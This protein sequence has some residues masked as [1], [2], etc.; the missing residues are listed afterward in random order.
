MHK[1]DI[2][3]ISPGN[4]KNIYQDLSKKYTIND[5]PNT[6]IVC[7][8]IRS[9]NIIIPNN[10]TEIKVNDNLLIFLKPEQISTVEKIFQ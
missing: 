4:T 5:L 7:E 8:I 3:F 9:N 1:L 6:I 10:K 2:L